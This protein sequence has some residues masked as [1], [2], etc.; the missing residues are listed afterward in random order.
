MPERHPGSRRRPDHG[1]QWCLGNIVVDQARITTPTLP[2]TSR[3]QAFE[4]NSTS[5]TWYVRAQLICAT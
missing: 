1:H 5:G 3:V 4:N 2:F